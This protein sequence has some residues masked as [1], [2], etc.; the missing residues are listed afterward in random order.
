MLEIEKGHA[1]AA[2]SKQV[3]EGLCRELK[4]AG[5]QRRNHY[6]EIV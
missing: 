4:A 2:A 3:E 1:V 6:A 5:Q